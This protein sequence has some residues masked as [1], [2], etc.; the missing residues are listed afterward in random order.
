MSKSIIPETLLLHWSSNYFY[1]LDTSPS[2]NVIIMKY[3]GEFVEKVK[4]PEKYQ[5]VKN[6]PIRCVIDEDSNYYSI[7][8]N[9]ETGK[10]LILKVNVLQGL[11]FPLTESKPLITD[12]L[13]GDRSTLAVAT[14]N[15][16]YGMRTS[17]GE[18]A[19]IIND[20][21]L[22]GF[23]KFSQSYDDYGRYATISHSGG[24]ITFEVPTGTLVNSKNIKIS[25]YPPVENYL[26]LKKHLISFYGMKPYTGSPK[27]F[28]AASV[29]IAEPVRGYIGRTE[30]KQA[31]NG[32]SFYIS[33]GNCSN[34]YAFDESVS[35]FGLI[36]RN[37]DDEYVAHRYLINQ[38]THAINKVEET[39]L[40]NLLI[41]PP[42]FCKLQVA[43]VRKGYYGIACN[44]GFI[45]LTENMD[46]VNAVPLS[47]DVSDNTQVF[48]SQDFIAIVTANPNN[49]QY[50][51]I[52][53][54]PPIKYV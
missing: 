50:Q 29:S 20:P 5:L 6:G 19:W 16:V 36:C 27:Q 21:N 40:K 37:E 30:L 45:L 31:I 12:I 13:S 47:I 38:Q 42:T 15:Y 4:I 3:S 9:V 44:T 22:K 46:K 32:T 39:N 33:L 54:S 35:S 43:V 1:G 14:E 18:I 2:N 28:W 26:S 25:N 7:R 10:H 34:I 8:Q 51:S 17:T 11:F 52:A 53:Y 48:A 23:G 41:V 24:F 49:I